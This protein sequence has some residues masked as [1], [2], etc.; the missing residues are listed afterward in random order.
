MNIRSFSESL[1]AVR[2]DVDTFV[3]TIDDGWQQGRGAFGGL[4][5]GAMVRAACVAVADNDAGGERKVRS[6]TAELLGPVLV[7]VCTL[8]LDRLRQGAGVSAVRV[9]LLQGGDELCQAVVVMGKKRPNTPSWSHTT[10]PSMPLWSSLQPAPDMAPVAPIFTSHF[11]FR[12]T[13]AAP[14]SLA[15]KAT[16]AGFIQPKNAS[17]RVDAAV[18][19]GLADAWW[20]AA[21]AMFDSMR[22]TATITYAL[23]ICAD[24][25]VIDG[26]VPFFH[27]A[28]A[29]QAHDGYSVE[30]RQL[31]TPD[32]TLVAQNQQLFAIIR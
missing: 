23:E 6:V 8:R 16:A 24:L 21:L 14:M 26:R 2:I 25:D 20:P 1:D 27:C 32:G 13:G 29:L 17:E 12:L 31:W 10:A 30:H 15:E 3:F 19:A 11:N 18:V 28:E 4:V 7:G 22:P 5:I 9:R